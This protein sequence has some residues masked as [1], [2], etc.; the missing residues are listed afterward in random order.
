[1]RVAEGRSNGAI[2]ERLYVSR[3][4]VDAHISQ[5]FLKFNLRES[6]SDDRRVLAV[7][8]LLRSDL[9]SGKGIEP[10]NPCRS[11]GP[12]FGTSSKPREWPADRIRPQASIEVDLETGGRLRRS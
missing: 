5:I 12:E 8:A 6:P 10:S 7:L 11:T 2:A 4:T 1:V 9:R 3:K